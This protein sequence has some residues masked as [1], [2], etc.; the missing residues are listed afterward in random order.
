MV[1]QKLKEATCALRP[2][3]VAD[4]QTARCRELRCK[5][6]AVKGRVEFEE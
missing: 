5:G 3:D 4:L 2:Q 1:T 6:R